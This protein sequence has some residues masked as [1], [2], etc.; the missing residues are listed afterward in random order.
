[1]RICVHQFSI[2]NEAYIGASASLY[3]VDGNGGKTSTLATLYDS[4]TGSGT[5]SNPQ[6]LDSEGKFSQPVYIDEPVIAVVS[7]LSFTDHDTGII[8]LI[9]NH[10]GDWAT[11]TVYAINDLVTD[12]ATTG[13]IYICTAR[14]TAGTFAADRDTNQYWDLFIDLERVTDWANKTGAT[15][16][17][18][19]YSAKEYAQGTVVPTGSAKDWAQQAEDS[20][21]TG[22]GEY[23]AFHHAAK[24]LSSATAAAA[25]AAS[26]TTFSY[27]GTWNATTNTPTIPAAAAA[28]E[29]HYYIVATAGTTSIDG[30]TDWQVADWLVSN[31]TTWE[32]IDN[33]LPALVML[34]NQAKVLTAGYGITGA[35]LTDGAT[36]TPNFNTSNAFD[37]TLAASRTLAFPT[38]ITGQT[39]GMM[40]IDATA[41]GGDWTVTLGAGLTEQGGDGLTI[42]SGATYRIWVILKSG[43]A[44]HVYME[45]LL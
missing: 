25:S 1:M 29:G 24:A 42:P 21:V 6:T 3:T 10:R 38:I 5:L 26:I 30:E 13:N 43:T 7:G 31:G 8:N 33:S 37:W 20:D 17:G 16:D 4:T 23:S 11:S 2:A 41:S 36:V 22:S 45:A 12:A 32:K 19:E 34:A 40:Y 18:S 28:N 14:H 44:G 15:V 35:S 27:Q 9:I 39:K